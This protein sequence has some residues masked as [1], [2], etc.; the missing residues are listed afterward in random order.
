MT[1]KKN[2]IKKII[3]ILVIFFF[4][5][6]SYEYFIVDDC[7]DHGGHWSYRDQACI[8]RRKNIDQDE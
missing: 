8:D 3:I 7:F 2:N 1:K 4:S 6:L 5:W